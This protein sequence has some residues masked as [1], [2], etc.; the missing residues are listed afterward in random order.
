MD[1]AIGEI[2]ASRNESPQAIKAR[3]SSAEA[4]DMI[5]ESVI[6]DKV[7]D[8]LLEEKRIVTP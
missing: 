3:L 2:A 1:R 7:F 5:K 6:R 8:L 4:L